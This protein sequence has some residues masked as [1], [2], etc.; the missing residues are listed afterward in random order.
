MRATILIPIAALVITGVATGMLLLVLAARG[1]VTFVTWRLLVSGIPRTG[2]PC[3][4]PDEVIREA[5]AY[6]LARS[7]QKFLGYVDGEYRTQSRQ[8]PGTPEVHSGV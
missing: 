7:N 8:E 2:E 3:T 6:N 5:I 1:I 4:S